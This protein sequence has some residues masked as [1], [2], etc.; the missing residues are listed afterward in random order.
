MTA[1][2]GRPALS[3]AEIEATWSA[4]E[5]LLD[6]PGAVD[7]NG[8]PGPEV[9]AWLEE[10]SLAERVKV[11][12]YVVYLRY[13]ESQ[14][15]ALEQLATQYSAKAKTLK[16]RREWIL[17]RVKAYMDGRNLRQIAG[18]VLPGFG[19]RTNGGERPVNVLVEPEELPEVFQRVTVEPDRVKI[20]D[21]ME[22]RRVEVLEELD[23]TVYAELAPRAESLRIL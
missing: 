9:A 2:K 20:R 23:G 19:Y 15:K 6:E 7:E 14:Q 8:A 17:G 22:A 11:D 13:L 5:A 10:N 18:E 21:T 4:L 3:L 16:G 1:T 12:G